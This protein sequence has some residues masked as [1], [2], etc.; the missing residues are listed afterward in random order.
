[1][2][3]TTKLI[4]LDSLLQEDRVLVPQGPSS[5]SAVAELVFTKGEEGGVEEG[6]VQGSRSLNCVSDPNLW[7]LNVP[8]KHIIRP[9]VYPLKPLTLFRH[10]GVPP[11]PPCTFSTE[12]P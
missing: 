1:M 10:G 2:S 8:A 11:P 12:A 9:K 5:I 4:L 7:I 3:N 6:G